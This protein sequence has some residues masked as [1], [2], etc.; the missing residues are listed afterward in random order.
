MSEPTNNTTHFGFKS[1]PKE[2]KVAMVADVFHSVAAKYDI[3]NDVMSMGIHRL[4]KRFTIDCSGVRAGQQVLDLAGGTGDITA[5]FSKRVGPSGKVVLADI[6][7]SMLN[8]G[9]DKLRDLGLVNNI[10]FVQANAEALPFADN[11]FDIV[12]IGFGLRNVTDKDA[13]L[14]S[15]FR[16][17]K[18]GGRL[19]VLE[20]S[21]PESEL[22]SKAYDLYS[23]R[24][25]PFMGQLIANDKESY[26][27]LAE[28]IRMHPDQET[29]KQMMQDAG[30]QEVSYH[31]LT[32]GIVALHR[33]YKF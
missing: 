6:N 18:P 22:L 12:S 9:R 14:R 2:Q 26:Q 32:G 10:E 1:V 15:M 8:V 5:L 21:K 23:F 24:I 20:F 7:E 17:L 33:G 3:M 16:V 31:N 28:S 30:F 27:Y 25:L 19:L 29:L 13:A 11:S 4:W